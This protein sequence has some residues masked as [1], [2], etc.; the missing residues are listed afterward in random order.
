VT[1]GQDGSGAGAADAVGGKTCSIVNVEGST[2]MKLLHAVL[3][4]AVRLGRGGWA[5]KWHR[6]QK[7]TDAFCKQGWSGAGPP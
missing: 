6:V 1:D 2:Y 4:L 3:R 5:P 7:Q